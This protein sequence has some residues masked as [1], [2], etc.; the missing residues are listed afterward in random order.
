MVRKA[1]VVEDDAPTRH[2]LVEFLESDGCVVD[3]AEDG[4][5][6]AGLLAS[7]DYEIVLLDLGLPRASG[8]DVM[9]HIICTR[10]QTLANTI[11]V[12]GSDTAKVRS[13][14]PEVCD[15]LAKPIVPADLLAAIHRCGRSRPRSRSS[16]L[17]APA[18]H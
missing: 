1:L 15:A 3:T 4:E 17:R 18:Q 14:F 9:E 8:T 11:I 5:R 16:R 7:E 10:P 2:S 13:L 6:A 12:T